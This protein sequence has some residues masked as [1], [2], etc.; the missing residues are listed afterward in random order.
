ME[1]SGKSKAEVGNITALTMDEINSLSSI[2]VG[3]SLMEKYG[4]STSGLE[5]LQDVKESLVDYYWSTK[6]DGQAVRKVG[7]VWVLESTILEITIGV[8]PICFILI[9]CITMHMYM[10][11]EISVHFMVQARIKKHWRTDRFLS[12]Q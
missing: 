11:I 2:G 6:E 4:L 12:E 10:F 1:M 8:G 3:L 7:Y 9:S 5:R